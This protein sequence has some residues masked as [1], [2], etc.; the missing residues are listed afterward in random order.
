MK[1]QAAFIARNQKSRKTTFANICTR[2]VPIFLWYAKWSIFLIFSNC[3]MLQQPHRTS[4]KNFYSKYARKLLLFCV[5]M[6]VFLF[7]CASVLPISLCWNTWN[8]IICNVSFFP[9]LFIIFCCLIFFHFVA[10]RIALSSMNLKCL[11]NDLLNSYVL[12]HLEHSYTWIGRFFR[13]HIHNTK[14]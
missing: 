10:W 3:H 5:L 13:L 6:L 2:N 12:P 8:C 4:I 11:F 14:I 1:H 7:L 9:N